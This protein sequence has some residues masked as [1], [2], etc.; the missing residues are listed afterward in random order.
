MFKQH[1]VLKRRQQFKTT[2]VV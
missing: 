1:Y 2:Q